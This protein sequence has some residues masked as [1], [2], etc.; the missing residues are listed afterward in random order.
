MQTS[1]VVVS[2]LGRVWL[3]RVDFNHAAAVPREIM[4][5]AVS[6]AF[7]VFFCSTSFL[8]FIPIQLDWGDFGPCAGLIALKIRDS[9]ALFELRVNYIGAVW[10]AQLCSLLI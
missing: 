4:G 8:E 2:Y 6:R 3:T 10:S 7:R 9:L 5:A 1:I